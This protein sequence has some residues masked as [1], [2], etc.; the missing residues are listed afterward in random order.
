MQ[1]DVLAVIRVAVLE[2]EPNACSKLY[3]AC[4][5]AAKSM[6]ARGLVTYT[7]ADEPGTSLRAAG[8]VYGGMTGGGEW[9]REGR[10]RQPALFPDRKLR[11]WAPWSEDAKK[12]AA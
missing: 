12:A 7:H 4:A 1:R 5:K 3:G 11:W 10:E 9:S 2:G 6:G 8:W